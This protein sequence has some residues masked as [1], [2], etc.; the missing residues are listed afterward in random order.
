MTW[1]TE[2]EK[3]GSILL[4]E[5]RLPVDAYAGQAD[6]SMLSICCAMRGASTAVAVSPVVPSEDVTPQGAL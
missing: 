4:R 3:I 2:Y 6:A 5:C 1:Q